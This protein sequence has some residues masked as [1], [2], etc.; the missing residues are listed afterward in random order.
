MPIV[1]CH[2]SV[3]NLSKIASLPLGRQSRHWESELRRG[4]ERPSEVPARPHDSTSVSDGQKVTGPIRGKSWKQWAGFTVAERKTEATNRKGLYWCQLEL[5]VVYL[6]THTDTNTQSLI[7]TLHLKLIL[8]K[9]EKKKKK[10]NN[11]A[12]RCVFTV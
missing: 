7:Y 6:H 12:L 8:L 1:P 4:M 5:L 3:G 9:K 2:A 10:Q 11:Q